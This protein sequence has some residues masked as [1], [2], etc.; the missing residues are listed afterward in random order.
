[1]RSAEKAY[2]NTMNQEK[3]EVNLLRK[4]GLFDST[5]IIVGIVIGSGIFLTTGIIA[6][7]IP[8]PTLILLAWLVGGLLSL[9]GALVY[10][11][12]GAAMPQA[13]GQ[14]VYLRE[15]YGPLSGFLF[16]WM[17]FLVYQTGSIAA[18]AVAFAEYF[19]YFFPGLAT[20]KFFFSTTITIFHHSFPYSLS[21]GQLVA[22]VII[23]LLSILNYIGLTL[24]SIIQNIS[25]I[26]KIGTLV[27]II[28]FGFILGKGGH[29]EYSIASP[30]FSL[31][32]LLM[33]FGVAMIAVIFT[34]D[35]WNNV[36]FAAGEIKNPG[37]NLPLSLIFGTLGI[38]ALY[39][40]VNYVYLYALPLNQLV[41]V[42]RVA[43]KAATALFGGIAPS[44]ISAA[45]VIST[46]GALNGTIFTGP[47]VY[48]AMAKD[49]LFFK[50]VA[51]VHPHFRTPGFSIFTQAVWACLLTLTGTFEQIFTYVTFAALIFY[52]AGAA[53]IF[54]LRKKFP[55]L[56]RPY[57]SWGYPWVPVIFIVAITVLLINTL[58]NKPVES[59]AGLGIV[60]LGLPAYYYWMR[61]GP[62][63]P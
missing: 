8:S 16:G 43:E 54:T 13:G 56:P 31:S 41:G 6:K 58:I 3:Q 19:G 27:A 61:K 52:I 7:S 47:R 28:A 21:M 23:I 30:G 34:Y 11:E 22:L 25:T 26:L 12:L 18:L 37:R 45:V 20:T 49:K 5:M 62:K 40:V 29:I 15:A 55:D 63:N 46:F 17:M 2:K 53:S 36:N 59:L 35:G 51:D 1:V 57:K 9:A 14:Y 42:V 38:T 32:K 4:L 10:A 39:V 44:L 33:G 60:A 50:R 24:G 48:Y